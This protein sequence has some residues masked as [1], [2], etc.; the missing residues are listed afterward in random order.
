V[1]CGHGEVKVIGP[2]TQATYFEGKDLPVC[3]RFRVRP[4]CAQPVLGVEADQLS[5]TSVSL[6]ELWGRRGRR[7]DA[8]LADSDP[9]EAVGQLETALLQRLSTHQVRDTALA[10]HAVG[11]LTAGVGQPAERVRD[12]ARRLGVS[13]RHLRDVFTASVGVSPKQFARITR[14]RTVL[15]GTGP[16][17]QLAGDAGYY[18][19]SHMTAEFRSMMHVTPGAYAA[20]RLPDAVAC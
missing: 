20:G 18:D 2:R 4:G 3:V 13:E 14:V 8:E 15:S 19:Q 1:W 10:R 7:L 9:A 16:L 11:G 17:A 12:T 5:D 6:S